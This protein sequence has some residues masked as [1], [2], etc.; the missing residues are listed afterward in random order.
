[1][2]PVVQ[3]TSFSESP[4]CTEAHDHVLACRRGSVLCEVPQ[5][6]LWAQIVWVEKVYQLSETITLTLQQ[7]KEQGPMKQDGQVCTPVAASMPHALFLAR[8]SN[9]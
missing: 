6:C 2:M 5:V 9:R 1:M 7:P 3:S 4:A 8:T